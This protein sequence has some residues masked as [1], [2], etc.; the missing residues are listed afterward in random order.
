SLAGRVTVDAR[1]N[2]FRLYVGIDGEASRFHGE[3]FTTDDQRASPDALGELAG[4]R[5]GVVAG[6][7][8]LGTLTLFQQKLEITAGVRG[9]LYHA[10]PV[11]L[12]GAD[13]RASFK[14]HA[15]RWLTF[16]GGVG[17]YQQPPSFPVALPGIDTFALS[18]GLQKAI[19]ASVGVEAKIP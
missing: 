14:F 3:N 7:F 10:G 9:D 8:A 5:D 18:L 15:Q 13:P 4:D 19:Q 2:R 16:N 11:T 1:W 12:L 6:A 17:L